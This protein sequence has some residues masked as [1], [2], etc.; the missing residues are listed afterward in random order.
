MRALLNLIPYSAVFKYDNTKFFTPEEVERIS[1]M[2]TI[3]SILFVVCAILLVTF[4][5]LF[6]FSRKAVKA[7]GIKKKGGGK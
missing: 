1:N 5:L 4:V 2:I 7:K 6:V 3:A